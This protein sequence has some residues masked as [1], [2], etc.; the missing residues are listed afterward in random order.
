LW[1]GGNQDSSVLA[2]YHGCLRLQWAAVSDLKPL[3]GILFPADNTKEELVI[4]DHCAGVNGLME[5]STACV[6][7]R[8]PLGDHFNLCI[9]SDVPTCSDI[10]NDKEKTILAFQ[11][12]LLNHACSSKFGSKQNNE[13]YRLFPPKTPELSVISPQTT[14]NLTARSPVTASATGNDDP[15]AMVISTIIML[16]VLAMIVCIFY[17]AFA[18]VIT[19]L[20]A[21]VSSQ[22]SAWGP[23]VYNAGVQ[24]CSTVSSFGASSCASLSSYML[25]TATAAAGE[26]SILSAPSGVAVI[27]MAATAT[28]SS[29]KNKL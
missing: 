13:R 16:V 17:A 28:Q 20:I 12:A 4:V 22:G 11:K 25:P 7:V 6:S 8:N 14:P 21:T 18:V 5:C 23:Y 19:S 26:Y 3:I 15:L 1:G 24:S 9:R 29:R 2:F 10:S 27:A